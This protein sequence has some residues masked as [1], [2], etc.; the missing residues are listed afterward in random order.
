M[1]F[2]PAHDWEKY[3]D[4]I[5]KMY[6]TYTRGALKSL[7]RRLDIPCPTISSRAKALG[8]DRCVQSGRRQP[9]NYSA[10]EDRII[11]DHLTETTRQ[12]A[13]RLQQAGYPRDVHS[14]ENRLSKLRK[15][16]SILSN[17]EFMDEKDLFTSTRLAPL[18]GVSA[19]QVNRWCK[20]GVL[21]STPQAMDSQRIRRHLIKRK[22]L[23]E[24]L[25]T[26]QPYWDHRLCDQYFLVD[27]IAGDSYAPTKIQDRC[28]I[29]HEAAGD[30]EE[31]RVAA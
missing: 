5:R 27:I 14:V 7:S 8:I 20:I 24:F 11:R 6:A 16:N 10:Q 4:A 2:R 26:R 12:I 13:A 15:K 29:R 23:R 1:T 19:H 17:D 31:Y 21:K 18:M 22:D 9:M 25:L 3:D 30:Y 28:G